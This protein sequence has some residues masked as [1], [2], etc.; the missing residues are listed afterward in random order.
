MEVY[1]LLFRCDDNLV[2]LKGFVFIFSDELISFNVVLVCNTQLHAHPYD[3]L[4]IKTK[5][6]GLISTVEYVLS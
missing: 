1:T 4:D 2:N 6:H 5:S 3:R